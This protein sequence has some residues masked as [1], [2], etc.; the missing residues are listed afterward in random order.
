MKFDNLQSLN[1][2]LHLRCIELGGRAHPAQKDQSIDDMFKTEH[3]ELRPSGFA[4]DGYVEKVVRVRSTCL[5]QYDNNRYSV[6]A[7]YAGQHI[8]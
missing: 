4:F 7:Q 1:A 2:W 8:L 5:A 6:P 3:A